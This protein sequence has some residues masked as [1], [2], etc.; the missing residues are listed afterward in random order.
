MGHLLQL[1]E[2]ELPRVMLTQ[3]DVVMVEM[4]SIEG[5]AGWFLIV[6]I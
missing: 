6:Y 3:L 5:D 4:S 2:V 1:V